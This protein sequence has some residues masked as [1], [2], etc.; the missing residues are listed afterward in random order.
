MAYK[1]SEFSKITSLTV[2]AL[3]YYDEEQIL[4]PS[5]RGENGYRYYDLE[6]YKRAQLIVTLRQLDF[7][8][9]EI[10]EIVGS[11]EEMD[12]LSYYLEEKYDMVKKRIER[13]KHLLNKLEEKMKPIDYSEIEERYHV[14]EKVIP[15]VNVAAI[16]YQGKYDDVGKYIGT[17]Y[18]EIKG[19]PIGEP[20]S[21]YYD[22]SYMEVADIMLCIPV[23][24][25]IVG[26]E[27]TL[28]HLPK[29][30]VITTTHIGS[31]ETLGVAYKSL[32]DYGKTQ[33]LSLKVPSREI[34]HKGPG[35]IFKGNP[36]KYV[37]EIMIPYE[38]EKSNE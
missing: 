27:V 16:R 17:I 14:E 3:R 12:D 13:D 25:E 33:H 20:F 22:E 31:Y 38:E 30:K 1:I 29:Q 2:K 6:D 37:T 7:S 21:C 4:K 28:V 10:K 19:R 11:I 18:K 5:I 24:G 9:A 36:S 23:S 34:Y 8:I 15:E 32:L 35:M 26:K